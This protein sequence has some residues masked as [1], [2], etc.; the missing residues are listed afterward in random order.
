LE[1][2]VGI[3]GFEAG[4]VGLPS[5]TAVV[6]DD[7]GLGWRVGGIV[8]VVEGVD[9]E[10]DADK[11][12]EATGVA[13]AGPEDLILPAGAFPAEALDGV[14]VVDGVEE[15]GFQPFPLVA[16]LIA[17]LVEPGLGA[18]TSPEPPGGQEEG[19]QETRREDGPPDEPRHGRSPS[20]TAI[21]SPGR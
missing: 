5:A 9:V 13:V 8:E 18:I 11:S 17:G 7:G 1:D 19:G 14:E 15:S 21:G 6:E 2:V 12:Q 4:A 20:P 3:D 10:P 16:K